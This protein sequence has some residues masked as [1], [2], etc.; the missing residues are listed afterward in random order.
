MLWL[1]L[2][3]HVAKTKALISCAVTAQL[4]CSF[5][6]AYASCLFYY[7]AAQIIFSLPVQKEMF[8][9]KLSILF[10][11]KLSVKN[12]KTCFVYDKD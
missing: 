10:A 5:V 11:S 8:L 7:A 2:P 12:N 4:I 1:S 6:I 3:V 9:A